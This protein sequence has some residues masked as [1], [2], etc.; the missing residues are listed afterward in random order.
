MIVSR[1]PKLTPRDLLTQYIK[2]KCTNYMPADN[3]F[4]KPNDAISVLPL[5]GML[6]DEDVC[7]SIIYLG[8][9]FPDN[10]QQVAFDT[11]RAKGYQ[12][13]FN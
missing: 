8:K 7:E 12:L 13:S 2:K 5:R 11:L 1:L 6:H 4:I 10:F 3:F 9:Y